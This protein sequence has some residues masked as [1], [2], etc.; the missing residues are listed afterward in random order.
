MGAII[1]LGL[2]Y[3]KL[4]FKSKFLLLLIFL[5]PFTVSA[6]L[7]CG[8]QS[9]YVPTVTYLKSKQGEKA[10]I[11]YVSKKALEAA[12]LFKKESKF[13]PMLKEQLDKGVNRDIPEVTQIATQNFLSVLLPSYYTISGNLL[14]STMVS[15]HTILLILI[16]ITWLPAMFGVFLMNQDKKN[17]TIVPII[18]H[19]VSSSQFLF[20]KLFAGFLIAAMITI[21]SVLGYCVGSMISSKAIGSTLQINTNI[22]HDLLLIGVIGSFCA[23]ALTILVTQIISDLKSQIIICGMLL[24]LSIMMCFICSIKEPVISSSISAIQAQIPKIKTERIPQDKKVYDL[25]AERQIYDNAQIFAVKLGSDLIPNALKG[26]PKTTSVS[27]SDSMNKAFIS[28]FLIA[29]ICTILSLGLTAL[30]FRKQ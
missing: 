13:Y 14:D 15:L 21:A 22:I 18:A 17:L 1:T 11:E 30:R 3:L 6:I 5:I 29:G 27:F 23:I 9:T 24:P 20:S 19:G 16:S 10:T 26:L 25:L 4:L 12:E 2:H 7:T 8:L 28:F